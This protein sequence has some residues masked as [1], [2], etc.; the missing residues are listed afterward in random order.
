MT[1][2]FQDTTKTG[3]PA[4]RP[5]VRLWFWSLALAVLAMVVVGGA[6]RL[7]DSGLS[8]VEWRPVTGVLPPFSTEAWLLELEKY[9]QIPEYQQINRGMSLEEFKFIYWWEWGHRFLGRLVGV[10]F[11]IPFIFFLW[12]GWLDR[13]TMWLSLAA[14]GLGGIQGAIGWWMVASGLTERVDVSPYRLATHL[15]LAT[16]I[17]GYLVWL[18]QRG[19]AGARLVAHASHRLGSLRVGA[20]LFAVLLFV[21][22]ILGAFVAGI[23]AG[24][25]YREWPTMG[26]ML[27]PDLM[28][29]M[30]PWWRNLFEDVTTVQ[31]NHRMMGYIVL[32]VALI[33]T[34]LALAVLSPGG[35]RVVAALLGLGVTMQAGLG[36]ATLLTGVPISA[37]LAHQALA[38][39]LIGLAVTH[40][41]QV[42]AIQPDRVAE[43]PSQ[44]ETARA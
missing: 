36:I 11:L 18:A 27:I 20:I 32:I 43:P 10:L 6:T 7:T 19:Q 28:Y 2:A 17:F 16:V 26:G 15:G 35:A 22:M 23:D 14:F 24:F 34:A 4:V 29:G 9:R 30:E 39:V 5:I 37:A 33:Q 38:I 40:L 21:Q 12:R 1:L 8:I 41:R 42:W 25:A 13:K 3:G 44:M 31:F